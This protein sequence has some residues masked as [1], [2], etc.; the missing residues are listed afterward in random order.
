M[1]A[2]FLVQNIWCFYCFILSGSGH[3]IELS[4]PENGQVEQNGNR[5]RAVA[6][7]SCDYGYTLE[8]DS[9]RS[10]DANG[11]WS[12]TNPICKSR[13]IFILYVEYQILQYNSLI[14][15]TAPA[16]NT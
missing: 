10:C 13:S 14:R 2:I 3:C 7:Y 5:E 16:F 9:Q 11:R 12:G 6:D 1:E 4:D 8:G 15:V